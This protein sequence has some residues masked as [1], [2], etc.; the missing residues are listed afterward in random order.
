MEKISPIILLV[1]Y[2]ACLAGGLISPAALWADMQSTNYVIWADVF[3][4]GGSED[5]T[6]ANYRAMESIGEGLI[7]SPTSTSAN[8]GLK[9]GFHELYA[10]NYLTFTV[11]SAALNLGALSSAAVSSGNHT[12]TVDTN[13]GNGFSITVTGATLTSGVN[14]IAAIGAAEAA[15]AP[16]TAQFGIN[17]VANTVPAAGANPSGTAPIGTAANHYNVVDAFAFNSGATV[18]TSTTAVNQTV[19]TVSYIANIPLGQPNGTYTTTLTY[20][21]TANF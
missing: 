20:A 15:S 10:D 8:Y 12:M 1:L 11:G 17:L 4:A 6:S 16:G 13:A 9:A 21:A 3:N 18:A 5:S 14:T 19:F 7:L 2:G